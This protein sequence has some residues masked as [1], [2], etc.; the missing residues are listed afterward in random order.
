MS[1]MLQGY[2]ERNGEISPPVRSTKLVL[3]RSFLDLLIPAIKNAKSSITVCAYAWRWYGFEPELAI[4]KF[5]SAVLQAMRR[6][7]SVRV[8]TDNLTTSEQL[9]V[10]GFDAVHIG[11]KV[12]LH[13]KSIQIDENVL[14]IGSH[15]L[16]KSATSDNYEASIF[17]SDTETNLQFAEYFNRLWRAAHAS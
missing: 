7:V 13:T 17:T 5:N 10:L 14:I 3:D 1:K 8:I 15:N 12:V 2:A 11:F 16:T 4:Q 9:N 6:G